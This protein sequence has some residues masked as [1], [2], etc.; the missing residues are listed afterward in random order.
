MPVI[1]NSTSKPVRSAGVDF[2]P[3]ENKFADGALTPAQLAQVNAAP[4]LEIIAVPAD[5]KAALPQKS[6]ESKA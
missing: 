5:E 6:Q 1:K 4:A 2:K 3:G